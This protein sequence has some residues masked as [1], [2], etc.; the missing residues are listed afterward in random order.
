MHHYNAFQDFNPR[1]VDLSNMNLEKWMLQVAERMAENSH[2][3][4]ARKVFADLA[5]NS[6]QYSSMPLA[7]VPWDLLTDVE[8][9]KDR[10]RAQEILKFFQ[11]HGY[12]M[13]RCH[14]TWNLL[15]F[16][17]DLEL[18]PLTF[19]L[20]QTFITFRAEMLSYQ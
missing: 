18:L 15:F 7:L 4:W 10:F 20:V 19:I 8:R 3:L 6:A 9:R 11:Y 1:P 12:R 2:A 5:D 16:W 14:G 17:T 13:I